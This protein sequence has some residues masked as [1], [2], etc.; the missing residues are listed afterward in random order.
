MVVSFVLMSVAC[1]AGF[2]WFDVGY[3]G[4]TF[5]GATASCES[6]ANGCCK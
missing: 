6:S 2:R 3:D 5:R 1:K 4:A